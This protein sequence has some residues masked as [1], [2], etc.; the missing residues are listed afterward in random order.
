MTTSRNELLNEVKT[1]NAESLPFTV[2]Y[3]R[4]L[5]DLKITQK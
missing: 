1:S 3:N 5:P 2:S 4:T